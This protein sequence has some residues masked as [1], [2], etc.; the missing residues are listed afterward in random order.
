MCFQTDFFLEFPRAVQLRQWG[1]QDFHDL[2]KP[3]IGLSPQSCFRHATISLYTSSHSQHWLH[4]SKIHRELLKRETVSFLWESAIMASLFK[5]Y[6]PLTQEQPLSTANS[7][8]KGY[9]FLVFGRGDLSSWPSGAAVISVYSWF[10]KSSLLRLSLW[11]GKQRHFSGLAKSSFFVPV[12]L[13]QTSLTHGQRN[14]SHFELF[15]FW[16]LLFDEGCLQIKEHKFT[17]EL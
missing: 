5:Q 3:T 8:R 13:V 15:S 17:W 11:F 14:K 2:C 7:Q 1:H 16:D 6:P 9:W 10:L 12:L 4:D